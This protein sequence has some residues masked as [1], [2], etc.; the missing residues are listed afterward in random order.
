MFCQKCGKQ[1][2]DGSKHCVY[3][4]AKVEEIETVD[5]PVSVS[6][7]IPLQ[8]TSTYTQ[9]VP[10]QKPKKEKKPIS[11]KL[12]VGIVV[13]CLLAA[14]GGVGVYFFLNRSTSVAI[15]DDVDAVSKYVD[16]T[17]VNGKGSVEATY[18]E[19]MMYDDLQEYVIQKIAESKGYEKDDIYTGDYSD[20]KL[21][22]LAE[23]AS[24]LSCGFDTENNGSLKNGDKVTY[25]CSYDEAA[26]S[27][28]KVSLK[29]DEFSYEVEGLK[30]VE[31]LDLFKDVTVEWKLVNSAYSW[32]TPY[33]ELKVVNKSE[34]SVLKNFDY[35]VTEEG[36]GIAKVYVTVDEETLNELGYGV[37][38]SDDSMTHNG[39]QYI[40]SYLVDEKPEYKENS[41]SSSSNSSSSSTSNEIL[42]TYVVNVN[43]LNI[44]QK[45]S[46]NSTSLGFT[47]KG[48]TGYVYEIKQGSKYTWY[49][50]GTNKWIA[51]Y[52][53][54][55]TYTPIN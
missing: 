22:A 18:S 23:F 29:D 39:N 46:K 30:E 1:I 15:F 49:R 17:G 53:G 16:L 40:K 2:E 8:Q 11:K 52:N 54:W 42:G 28:A 45:A 41:S 9:Q 24:T 32:S 44:R 7:P 34:N 4:G 43:K 38:E 31:L 37:D 5:E 35:E 47:N 3:C 19:D 25:G 48:D 6:Q 13:L 51:N 14:A 50:I 26:A 33:Y 20:E 21:Y 10:V 55:V 36:N 27:A 12:I